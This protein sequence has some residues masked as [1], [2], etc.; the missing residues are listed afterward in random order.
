MIK[1][2]LLD[3]LQEK[4]KF[5]IEDCDDKDIQIKDNI[6][7]HNCLNKENSNNIFLYD[8]TEINNNGELNGKDVF[9]SFDETDTVIIVIS[10]D[11]I[12]TRIK[13]GNITGT[14]NIYRFVN[15]DELEVKIDF[16]SPVENFL[17]YDLLDEFDKFTHRVYNVNL[18][19]MLKLESKIGIRMY[20]FNV[21]YYL[22]EEKDNLLEGFKKY[23]YSFIKE[24]DIYNS[25]KDVLDNYF[26]VD[27]DS[28]CFLPE[29]FWLCHNGLTICTN[30][31]KT[32]SN[33]ITLSISD[34]FLLNGCQSV[35]CFRSLHNEFISLFTSD[36]WKQ[37]A[38][39][40]MLEFEKRIKFKVTFIEEEDL[41]KIKYYS[42]GLNTQ[43]PISPLDIL[44]NE[45]GEK[46]NGL[47]KSVKLTKPGESCKEYYCVNLLDF[48]K[49]YY[50]CSNQPGWAKNLNKKTIDSKFINN[51]IKVI[52]K[53]ADNWDKRFKI[54]YLASKKYSSIRGEIAKDNN[55]FDN[56]TC[57]K[58]YGLNYYASYCANQ[59]IEEEE[60]EEHFE[61]FKDK[62]LAYCETNKKQLIMQDFKEDNIFKAVFVTEEEKKEVTKE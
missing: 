1:Q 7:V 35:N 6:I 51:V 16:V 59:E 49:Y 48:V 17:S 44:V 61:E 40:I 45:Y 56:E 55:I 37:V 9:Q 3:K 36:E 50:D 5:G 11:D 25:N 52:K 28:V 12:Y 21:R 31:I 20:D 27:S 33:Q 32:K 43:R 41:D 34:T 26:N 30:C 46:I 62:I 58:K 60:I 19:Q 47:L 39:D 15:T 57:I 2:R 29:V 23:L 18:L 13:L 54:A 8:L 24:K 14:E 4:F 10:N 22:G 53:D 42:F 38:E